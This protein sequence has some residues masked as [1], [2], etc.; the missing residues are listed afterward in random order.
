MAGPYVRSGVDPGSCSVVDRA[1][2]ARAT[3]IIEKDAPL[4]RIDQE[5]TTGVRA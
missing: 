5:A 4:L 2:I 1:A 3:D